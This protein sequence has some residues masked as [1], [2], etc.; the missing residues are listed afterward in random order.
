[1]KNSHE[2]TK[3]II[4]I[5]SLFDHNKDFIKGLIENDFE[6][7]LIN[8]SETRMSEIEYENDFGKKYI[9]IMTA[10]LKSNFKFNDVIDEYCIIEM[11]ESGELT[12]LNFL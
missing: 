4:K 10:E 6:P 11:L 12:K 2:L 1:M 9:N 3:T 8:D 5:S 7:S